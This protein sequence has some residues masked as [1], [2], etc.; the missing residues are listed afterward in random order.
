MKNKVF[1][2]AGAGLFLALSLAI[3]IG[4]PFF[5]ALSPIGHRAFAIFLFTIGLWIFKPLGLP[6]AAGAVFLM[7]CLL[8]VGL[9]A[10]TV[11]SGFTNA[12]LWTLIPALFFGYVLYKTGLGTRIAMAVIT[13]FR[14]SYP[15]LVLA[16]VLIGLALSV[17]TPSITVR[18]SIVIPIA[19]ECGELCGLRKGSRGNS[20]ILLT[21]FAMALIPGSGWLNG[22]LTGPIIQG[23]FESVDGLQGLITF[24]SWAKAV[25]LPVEIS[26]VL[27]V[28]L[29][30]LV[31]KP[32]DKIA[33]EAVARLK[34]L[35]RG[36]MTRQERWTAAILVGVFVLFLTNGLHGIPDT[37]VCLLAV[38]ALFASGVLDAREFGTGISWD[39]VVFIGAALSL[40]QVF[41]QTGVSDWLSGI[42][43]PA[44]APIASGPWLFV[45]A[46]A[47]L[48]FLWRF[49]DI[50]IFIPTMS[51]LVPVLPEISRTYGISPMVWAALFIMAINA[52]FLEYQNMWALMSR[53]VTGDRSWKSSHLSAYGAV[54]FLSCL[55][56]L[57]FAV[58]L[59][60]KLGFF[61]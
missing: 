19:M 16:W 9:P 35:R 51:V 6:N 28:V 7:C 1:P 5:P 56:A 52:F 11:F 32:E 42:I 49:V 25:L 36:K 31:L 58:P 43:V 57:A 39:L 12:A 18:V 55:A 50:A 53:N 34:A 27:T 13:L 45:Y 61:S 2:L 33:P 26:A 47:I 22:A 23:L 4:L 46:A 21:A 60:E 59:W 24:D 30:C 20:L 10:A 3:A 54:Y 37:A 17:L 38:F 29:G 14:P 40:G 44:L 48:L 41:S 8:A 15:S